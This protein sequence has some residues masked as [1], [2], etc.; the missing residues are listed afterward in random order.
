VDGYLTNISSY[1][2]VPRAGIFDTSKIR[3]WI[4]CSTEGTAPKV[5][6][7]HTRV[8]RVTGALFHLAALRQVRPYILNSPCLSMKVLDQSPIIPTW[9]CEHASTSQKWRRSKTLCC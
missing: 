4:S 6:Y 5:V 3:P 8:T 2:H 7:E 9:A 1:S